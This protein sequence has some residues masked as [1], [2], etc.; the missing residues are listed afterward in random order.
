M[1]NVVIEV[2]LLIDESIVDL[3]T[4][5]RDEME[6]VLSLLTTKSLFLNLFF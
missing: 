2:W 5:F 4:V 3:T 1:V 6:E